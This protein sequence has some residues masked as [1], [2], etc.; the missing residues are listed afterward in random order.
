MTTGQMRFFLHVVES[1][2]F[3]RA[4][5]LCFCTAQGI[6]KQMDS[7]EQEIGVALLNRSPRGVTLT[8]AGR[9]FF[10]RTTAVL[11]QIDAMV[12]Q[13]RIVGERTLRVECPPHPRLLLEDVLGEFARRCPDVELSCS[14]WKD[15]EGR[16][17][18]LLSGEVD[19][20]ECILR[21]ENMA[22]GL[23]FVPV[24]RLPH[25]AL[26][27]EGHPLAARDTISLGDLEG[28]S[29]VMPHASFRMLGPYLPAGCRV[30]VLER[31]DVLAIFSRCFQ[32]RLY[33][34]KAFFARNLPPLVSVPLT[35]GFAELAGVMYRK[36]PSPVAKEF[37]ALVREMCPE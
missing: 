31:D 22:E 6:R 19:V 9:V 30:E 23:G 2:S 25:V 11:K 1:G 28:C 21:P 14:F 37:L 36:P 20:A 4:E 35:E 24:R 7:L 27:A 33:L 13:T 26:M 15:R 3:S 17:S 32:N 8:A 34:T 10:E 5:S 16:A 12:E 29:V 18:R